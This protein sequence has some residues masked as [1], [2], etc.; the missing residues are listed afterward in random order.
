MK[1]PSEKEIPLSQNIHHVR[2][3]GLKMQLNVNKYMRDRIM[4]KRYCVKLGTI[5]M[6]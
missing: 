2:T 1:Q 4:K 6:A 5:W 3:I